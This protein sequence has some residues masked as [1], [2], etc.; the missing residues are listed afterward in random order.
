MKTP[1]VL[2]SRIRQVYNAE[3]DLNIDR[4]E[5]FVLE[6]TDWVQKFCRRRFDERIA[7]RNYA[8]ASADRGGAIDRQGFLLVD[9]DL[10]SITSVST[11]GGAA[12]G[13]DLWL[14]GEDRI[15]KFRPKVSGFGAGQYVS[16]TGVWGYDGE[17]VSSGVLSASM[18]DSQTTLSSATELEWGMLLKVDSEYLQVTSYTG[19]TAT[20]V[21]GYNGSTA[22]AHSNNAPIY[23]FDPSY[24]VQTIGLRYIGWRIEQMKTPL[25]GQVTIGEF[26][27]PVKVDG[28]PAD[29]LSSVEKSGLVRLHRIGAIAS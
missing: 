27:Y 5:G 28:I 16:V 24:I 9:D 4:L 22:A 23:K 11:D 19:T 20:V 25:A 3:S 29:I 13:E 14:V 17:W 1:L 8:L 18:T 2:K 12:I 21:R 7:T 15:R 10:K 6:Y 26:T